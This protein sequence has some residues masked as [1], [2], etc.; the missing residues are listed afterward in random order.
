MEILIKTI[1]EIR[2]EVIAVLLLRPIDGGNAGM[3]INRNERQ[4]TTNKGCNASED[5]AISS[6]SSP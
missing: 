5:S 2:V 4:S 1:R 3:E 6:A